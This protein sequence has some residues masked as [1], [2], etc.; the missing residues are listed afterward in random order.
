MKKFV[1]ALFLTFLLNINIANAAI[2]ISPS[3]ID[4]DANTTKKDYLSSSFNVSGGKDE[5]V[6]FKVYPVFFK[7]DSHG[8]FV[9]LEDKGQ[10]NSL[11]G[12]IKFYPTEFTCSNG[13]TQKVRFT[14]TDLKTLPSGES[15]LML[16]LEDTNTKEVAI[17]RANGSIGGTI[18]I[19][20]RVGVPIFVDKGLYS[21]KASLDSLELKKTGE[22]YSCVYK[23]SSFG[24]S[25]IR[26]NGVGYLSEGNTL[27]KQFQV[28]GAMV[29]G[30]TTRE[31]TQPLILDKDTLKTDKEYKIKFVLTYPDEHNKEKILKREINFKPCPDIKKV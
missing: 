8:R 18:L 15:K 1:L 28:N 22:E 19:K 5:T 7:Y 23:I 21:K 31:Q 2:K 13:E 16:F 17:K 29:P 27:I 6:R 10:K 30:G 9:E 25:R 3:Y 26:Y 14:I 4:I 11:M 20:T 24:N 12:K